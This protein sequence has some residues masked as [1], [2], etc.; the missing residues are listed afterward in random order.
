MVVSG[1]FK[2]VGLLKDIILSDLSSCG[3]DWPSRSKMSGKWHKNAE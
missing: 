1:L 3:I 2:L